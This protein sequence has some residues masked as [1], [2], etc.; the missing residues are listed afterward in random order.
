M[1]VSADALTI[2]VDPPDS[3]ERAAAI[4]RA[5]FKPALFIELQKESA[6]TLRATT[7]SGHSC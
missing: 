3:R 4:E 5:A 1:K 7:T 2:L 6:A